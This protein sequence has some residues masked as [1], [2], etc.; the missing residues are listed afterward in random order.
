M[1]TIDNVESEIVVDGGGGGGDSA[2]KP[3]EVRVEELRAVVRELL[4]EE[5]QR[6]LRTEASR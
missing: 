2:D 4:C 1:V 5:F 6:Y 3:H